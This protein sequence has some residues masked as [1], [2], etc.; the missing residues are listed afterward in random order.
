MRVPNQ[1]RLRQTT[2][3]EAIASGWWPASNLNPTLPMNHVSILPMLLSQAAYHVPMFLVCLLGGILLLTR[4][5][6]LG[7]GAVWALLGAGLGLV[8][9]VASPLTTAALQVWMMNNNSRPANIGLVFGI[10]A[11]VFAILHAASF[12][13]VLAGVL[14]GSA[15]PANAPPGPGPA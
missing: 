13:L 11:A 14:V 3:A 12:G 9:S 2:P 8:V 15:K 10:S 6:H 4:R 7:P 1:N 5:P